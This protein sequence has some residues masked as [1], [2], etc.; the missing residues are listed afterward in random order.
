MRRRIC[1]DLARAGVTIRDPATT[2]VGVDVA[3]EPDATIEPGVHLRG[4]TR[5]GA[6]A[7]IDVG[8]VL[9]DV[10]VRPGA[11]VKPYTV[12]QKSVIG[13]GAQVGPFSHLRPESVLGPDVHVGNFV[14][15]K[16]TT[17]GRGSKANHLAYLGDGIIGERVNVGAGTIFCNYDGVRKHTTV[18]EDGCFIGSDSQLVAPVRVGKDAYI[19]TGT[20]VTRDVPSDA[21]AIGRVKQENKAGYATRLRERMRAM[22]DAEKRKDGKP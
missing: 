20:T 1:R 2:Y 11:H 8:A 13:E 6:G 12:A 9:E 21:L 17:M 22:A 14:E 16:K 4:K 7:R 19:A 18:L 3:I 10:E 5:I 15:T